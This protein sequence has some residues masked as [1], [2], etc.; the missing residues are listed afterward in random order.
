MSPSIG[1]T[2]NVIGGAAQVHSNASVQTNP[3][4]ASDNPPAN[5]N[6][7]AH[8][9]GLNSLSD[10]PLSPQVMHELMNLYASLHGAFA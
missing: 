3:A 7:A 6:L 5:P 9:P 2:S 1:S 4:P 8:P 10:Q